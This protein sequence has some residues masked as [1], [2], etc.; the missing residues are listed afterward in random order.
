MRPCEYHVALALERHIPAEAA[1]AVT[2]ADATLEATMTQMT[3][4]VVGRVTD[5]ETG[6]PVPGATLT[7]FVEGQDLS[8][9]R[10]G[11]TKSER[12]KT[13]DT[14]AFTFALPDGEFKYT[15]A[16][17]GFASGEVSFTVDG[18]EVAAG[19]VKLQCFKF[20]LSGK[21]VDRQVLNK[22]T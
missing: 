16:A 15:V 3:Y 20:K 17:P 8:T 21:C 1:V 4:K 13:D 22:T 7:K 6:G 14:G 9:P 19:D 5:V 12:T 11:Y 18:A 10:T 2:A